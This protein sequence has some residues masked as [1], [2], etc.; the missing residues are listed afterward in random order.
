MV[1][2][3]TVRNE[4]RCKTASQGGAKAS[5]SI[6]AWVFTYFCSL[7]SKGETA[8]KSLQLFTPFHQNSSQRH[9]KNTIN[10][11]AVD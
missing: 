4:L 2:N 5:S 6:Q 3:T 10:I 11:C 9:F 7:D 8:E 1:T